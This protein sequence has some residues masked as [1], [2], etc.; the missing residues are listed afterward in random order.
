MDPG[1]W[2]DALSPLSSLVHLAVET[3]D[4]EPFIAAAGTALGRPLGLVAVTG[5]RLGLAPDDV[6]GRRALAVAAAA[7]AR[8]PAI[9]PPGWAVIP[10]AH[11]GRRLAFLAVGGDAEGDVSAAPMLDLIAAL[12]GEQLTRAALLRSQTADLLRRLASGPGLGAERARRE[13]ATVGLALADAYRPAVV[14]WPGGAPGADLVEAFAHRGRPPVDGGLIAIVDGHITLLHPEGADAADALAWFERVV[15][16]IR[17]LAPT[18]RAHAIA[19]DEAVAVPGLGARVADLV[20]LCRFE[21]RADTAQ[22]VVWARQYAL[23]RLLRDTLAAPEARTFVEDRLGALIVW[24]REHRSDLLRV[25]EASLDF[26]RHD[27]AAS[28]CFMHRNTFRHRLRLAMELLGDDLQD[29]DSRLAV[30][31][32]LKLR[33]GPAGRASRTVSA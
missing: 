16:R 2:P 6:D 23:D 1:R 32:A 27:H 15:A 20:S 9:A 17:A 22:L 10:V 7:A 19:A 21:P 11:A 5:E 4:P 31:V 3:D 13:G 26:P 33:R 30:H 12:L 8:T 29:P 28:H 25:L 14:A 24:D 18:S